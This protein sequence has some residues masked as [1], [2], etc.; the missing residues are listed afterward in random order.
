M[1]KRRIKSILICAALLVGIIGGVIGPAFAENNIYGLLSQ[2]YNQRVIDAESKIRQ[3]VQSELEVQELRL[4]SEIKAKMKTSSKDLDEFIDNE[5]KRYRRN[6]AAYADQLIES[7]DF[8][9]EENKDQIQAKLNQILVSAQSAM[10]SLVSSYNP[11]IPSYESPIENPEQAKKPIGSKE[12]KYPDIKET[13]VDEPIKDASIAKESI[14]KKQNSDTKDSINEDIETN[15]QNIKH[16]NNK[17]IEGLADSLKPKV[18]ER[19]Y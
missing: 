18:I 5:T 2:W 19:S 3:G 17:D 15:K 9:N 13:D 8:S 10:D 7:M 4:K 11:P 12:E 6:I 16:E 1:K 14:V